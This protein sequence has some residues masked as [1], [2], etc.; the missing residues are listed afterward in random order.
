MS[1]TSTSNEQIVRDV[2]NEFVS[3]QWSFTAFN[4]TTEAK[5]RGAN[6]RH[7]NLKGVVHDM[8][9]NGEMDGYDRTTK[10]V[11]LAVRPFLY[12]HSSQDSDGV[13]NSVVV[14]DQ[15]AD[16][17]DITDDSGDSGDSGDADSSVVPDD[18]DDGIS[19]VSIDDLDKQLGC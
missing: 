1:G 11:G 5:N 4:I 18:S 7:N 12:V 8:F 9:L 17:P 19:L 15:D 16:E 10:D 3:K 14:T 6:D 2:V 13:Q